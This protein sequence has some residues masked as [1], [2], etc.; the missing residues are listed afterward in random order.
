MFDF[1]SHDIKE[2]D[3]LVMATDGLWDILSN[4]EVAQIVRSFLD[5][6]RTDPHR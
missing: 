6:N 3:A 5:E 1:A 4:E 2:D